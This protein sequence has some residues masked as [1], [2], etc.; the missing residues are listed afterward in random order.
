[1]VKN[2]HNLMESNGLDTPQESLYNPKTPGIINNDNN[3]NNNNS[4]SNDVNNN[5]AQKQINQLKDG[6]EI[7]QKLQIQTS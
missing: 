3:D 7:S 6:S 2:V 5:A 1:M 4:S